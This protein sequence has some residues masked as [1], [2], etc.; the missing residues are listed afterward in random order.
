MKSEKTTRTV[1]N[2]FSEDFLKTWELWKDYKK[3]S[4]GFQYKG[5]VSEQMAIKH[6]VDLS[7]G[8]EDKAVKIAEQ[9]MRRQ[10][11]GFFPLKETTHGTTTKQSTP[12]T[13]A[14]ET[15]IRDSATAE[16]NSRHGIRG[17]AADESHLKAV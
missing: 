10:W 14:S 1:T 4:F 9:S 3:E 2:P 16:F 12:K 15:V 7:D 13:G 11:Q 6:L 5:V 17:Q 8:D